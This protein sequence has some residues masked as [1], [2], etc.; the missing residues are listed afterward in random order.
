VRGTEK[1]ANP[2]PKALGHTLHVELKDNAQAF[3]DQLVLGCAGEIV[4]AV[5]DEIK[6]LKELN[7]AALAGIEV[8]AL[9]LL[10]SCIK[11]G[12][13]TQLA[14]QFLSQHILLN[15]LIMTVLQ[16]EA[17]IEALKEKFEKAAKPVLKAAPSRRIVILE[18]AS[19]AADVQSSLHGR[20]QPTPD[21]RSQLAAPPPKTRTAERTAELN[22]ARLQSKGTR[23]GL[24]VHD[25]E[26]ISVG[27]PASATA[28]RMV[29]V[30]ADGIRRITPTKDPKTGRLTLRSG[31]PPRKA[32]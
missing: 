4:K 25:A 27:L 32:R 9:G 11:V 29:V 20:L 22:R 1:L 13:D 14:D 3:F 16:T 17:D 7:P 8:D 26:S 2:A 24:Y 30:G 23:M 15:T 18:A 5:A 6:E 10:W 12:L 31:A 28:A 21:P 19:A